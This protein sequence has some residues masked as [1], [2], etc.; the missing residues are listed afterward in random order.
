M[1]SCVDLPRCLTAD[2]QLCLL[3]CS[4]VVK[5]LVSILALTPI[6]PFVG[7]E[8]VLSELPTR[9][10]GT[11]PECGDR[12]SYPPQRRAALTRER[13]IPDR[14]VHSHLLVLMVWSNCRFAARAGEQPSPESR[15][16]RDAVFSA[17][18]P[19]QAGTIRETDADCSCGDVLSLLRIRSCA[20]TRSN[21]RHGTVE[22]GPNRLESAAVLHAST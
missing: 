6:S 8:A 16:V 2:F 13:R 20:A 3:V 11:F 12:C 14:A 21:S 17:L 19:C 5:R 9:P 15:R 4:A 1:P 22:G 18:I 10:I 7:S